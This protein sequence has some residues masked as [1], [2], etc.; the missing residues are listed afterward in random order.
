MACRRPPLS[1]D[2]RT[3]RPVLAVAGVRRQLN[4]GYVRRLPIEAWRLNP[5]LNVVGGKVRGP[6]PRRT[7]K[8]PSL[9]PQRSNGSVAGK[10]GRPALLTSDAWSL[11]D[12]YRVSALL[13]VPKLAN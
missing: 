12:L 10:A 4:I 1:A 7:R 5:D 11:L 8:S 9:G 2:P 6:T 3:C 13:P